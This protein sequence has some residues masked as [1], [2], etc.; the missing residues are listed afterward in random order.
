[1]SCDEV[2]VRSFVSFIGYMFFDGIVGV[3]YGRDDKF[4]FLILGKRG[5]CVVSKVSWCCWGFK[6]K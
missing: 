6:I 5:R 3:S 1:M 2:E 4:T